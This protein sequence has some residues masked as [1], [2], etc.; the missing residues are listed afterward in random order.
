MR[1]RTGAVRRRLPTVAALA[2]AS[3]LLLA[4]CGTALAGSSGGDL[5]LLRI[6]RRAVAVDP[7]PR[8][9]EEADRRGW[10]ILTLAR[11]LS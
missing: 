7:D 2:T 9:R 3:A 1:Q 6:V 10:P 4:G 11:A 8:L 5:P